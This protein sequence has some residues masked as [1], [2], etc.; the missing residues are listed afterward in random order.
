MWC[1][2][3]VDDAEKEFSICK[4]INS[5]APKAFTE[6]INEIN[7]N[8]L[9]LSTDYVFDGKQNYPYKKTKIR[10]LYLNMVFQNLLEKNLLKRILRILKMQLS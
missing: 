4:K 8:L 7:G 10:I 6:A 3:S 1:I 9:Q 5:Y 2:Y